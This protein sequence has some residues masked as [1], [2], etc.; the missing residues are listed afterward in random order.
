MSYSNGTLIVHRYPLP[1]QYDVLRKRGLDG[2]DL[3]IRDTGT[4]VTVMIHV[5]DRQTLLFHE[6][7]KISLF[8]YQPASCSFLPPSPMLSSHSRSNAT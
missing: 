4:I 5:Q 7:V 6:V 2:I 3:M 8:V 1:N